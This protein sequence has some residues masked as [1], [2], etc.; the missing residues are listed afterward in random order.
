M[1][2]QQLDTAQKENNGAFNK[3]LNTVEKVGNKL[4]HPFMLFLYLT[5]ILIVISVILGSMNA[6]V[7]HPNTGETVTVNNLLS[8]EGIRYILGNTL[9]NFTGFA[10]LGLVLTMMLG[11]GLSERVGLF[12]SLMTKAI[13][14]TPKRIVSFMVV[15]IG[16][17][18]NIASDAAF[19]VI[20]PLAALVFLSLGRHPLAGLAA[21][22]AGAGIGFTANILIAGTDALLSGISTEVMKTI[23]PAIT[24]S[25]LDNWFFMSAST[26]L[27][28]FL[29]AFITDKIV[30]PRLG[31]YT[32]DKK[33]DLHDLS[34]LENRALRNTGIAALLYIA[35]IVVLLV[36]PNSPLLNDDG[37]ILR[38]P[39]LSG[40][41][42][43]LFGFFLTT[44]I[45]YG[46]TVKEIKKAADVPQIMAEAIKDL[47]GYIVLIFIIG[48][49]I[50][51]FNWTNI[52]TWMAVN[53]AALLHAINL[54]N[55]F[56]IVLFILLVAILSLF[57]ISGSALWSLVAPIFVPTFY[58]LDYHPALVQLA[59][60]V[61]ESSTNMVTPLNP[62]FAIILGFVLL[63]NKKAGIGTLMS[64]MIPYTI[65]FL[66]AWILLMLV[67]V[68]FNI[69]IGP[70][71]FYFMN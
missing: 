44:G 14:K 65:V 40:I 53:L 62:Y 17:L 36:I 60:R 19:V 58:L 70:G 30:E 27:L 21:G 37:T 39:F 4:P 41:V 46:V 11:I 8:K 54:T 10:P 68:F 25:P 20:P 32:G 57:I 34:P 49:F 29:G 6:S 67:F 26:F 55:I 16:I 22:L 42:P 47:S 28:A 71:V 35:A 2:T 13:T 69:P 61:G 66:I 38:S 12:S 59:Y 9:T 24:V 52:A 43:L 15:F 23:D 5:I 51:Y 7:V 64:L 31:T 56:A 63:Y 48:Q 33:A 3:F 50:G 45:T 1:K 18:G